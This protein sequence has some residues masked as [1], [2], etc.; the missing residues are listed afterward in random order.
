MRRRVIRTM[1]SDNLFVHCDQ[2]AGPDGCWPFLRSKSKRGYGHVWV[3]GRCESAHRFAYIISKGAIPE[4]GVVRHSC[5]NPP[6]VNPAHLLVGTQKDN[7][8]DR[9]SRGRGNQPRGEDCAAAKLTTKQIVFIRR[10]SDIFNTQEM[11]D[12]LGVQRSIVARILRGQ[13]WRHVTDTPLGQ[14]AVERVRG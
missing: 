4:G 5:D 1:I 14:A 12:M 6:C 9:E 10:C 2:S 8:S 7:A 3:E 13:L 11:A